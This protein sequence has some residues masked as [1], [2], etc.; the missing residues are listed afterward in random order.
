MVVS[1]DF[2]VKE[3]PL[4][5]LVEAVIFEKEMKVDEAIIV[6]Q[7]AYETITAKKKKKKGAQLDL[8]MR[9]KVTLED[10]ASIMLK[11]IEYLSIQKRFKEAKQIMSDSITEF[12]ETSQ[13]IRLL[14]ANAEL[15]VSFGEIK[16]AINILKNIDKTSSIWVES[17]KRLAHM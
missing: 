8:D 13:E 10:R 3:S 14:I 12:K 11:L 1:L 6:L 5:S 17:Q 15:S 4:Y 7:K 2:K 16:Q 9:L